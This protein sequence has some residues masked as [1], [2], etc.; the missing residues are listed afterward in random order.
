MEKLLALVGPT[1]VGKTAVGIALA[2]RL[3]GELIS[4]D[5]VAV[6]KKLDIG[7]A[8]PTQDEQARVRFHLIDVAEPTDDFTMTDFER[9]ASAA[10][11]EIRSRGKLPILLGGTGLYVRAVTSELSIPA[12]APQPEFRAARWAEVE[13]FGAPW[14]HAKLT[15]I[16]PPSA[17]KIQPGDGKRII[18]ALEVFEVT[19]QPL[20]SF[21]TPEGVHG[22]LK[23]GVQILGLD[24]EREALYERIDRRVDQMMTEGFIAEVRQLLDSGVP[25]DAKSLISLG[26]RHLVQFHC[27][28]VSLEDTVAMIKRDTRRYAKRQ[29]SWFRNDPAVNWTNIKE[30][31]S[32][33]DV[34]ER[35][36]IGISV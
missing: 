15:G 4:A 19:G 28:E 6:Y 30:G 1:A 13:E 32:A 17:A 36:E 14:L 5:A 27:D 29:L 16:D 33:E 12:A 24:R 7:S 23:P 21:H 22:I 34:A 31:D 3:N 18:R 11:S 35:L 2:E 25:R 20:S 10:I 9:L 26:Y 8:K